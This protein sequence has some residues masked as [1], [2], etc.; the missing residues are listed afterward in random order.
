MIVKRRLW[1]ISLFWSPHP[2]AA[3]AYNDYTSAKQKF[4]S[5]ETGRLRPGA[6][7]VLTYP[8]LNAVVA[9]EAPPASA[10]P[11][12]ALL[13][14]TSPPAP[15]SSISASWSVPPAANPVG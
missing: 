5:I 14:P 13:R 6:R 8:E 15:R 10:I 11:N 4:D 7:V 9:R 2:L 1:A 3:A 12:C